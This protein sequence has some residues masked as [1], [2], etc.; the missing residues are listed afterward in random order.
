VQGFKVGLCNKA[1]L[2]APHSLLCLANNCAIGDVFG[3]MS[4]RFQKLFKR[5]VYVHHYTQFMEVD[6]MAA[7]RESVRALQQAYV[8]AAN[9][10]EPEY[11]E[12]YVPA[13]ASFL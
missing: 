6:G 2:G 10:P 13:G 4:D 3:T 8:D 5:Q 9:M 1:P 7:A 11:E 12:L